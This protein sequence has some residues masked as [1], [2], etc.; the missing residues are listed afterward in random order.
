MRSRRW[1]ASFLPPPL[2]FQEQPLP[3]MTAKKNVQSENGLQVLLKIFQGEEL[4][5]GETTMLTGKTPKASWKEGPSPTKNPRTPCKSSVSNPKQGKQRLQLHMR[6][7]QS[8][9]YPGRLCA[10][11]GTF[12]ATGG[13][14]LSPIYSLWL[15]NYGVTFVTPQ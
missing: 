8:N 12:K 5:L 4:L 10:T 3:G 7:P 15:Y 11:P 14:P 6:V 9:F 13:R 1:L 2:R